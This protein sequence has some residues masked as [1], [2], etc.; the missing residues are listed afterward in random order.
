MCKHSW[1][2]VHTVYGGPRGGCLVR[3]YCHKCGQEQVGEVTRWRKPRPDEFDEPAA[4][5]AKENT[6]GKG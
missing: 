2:Y 4:E 5:A 1:S 3:R 6:D